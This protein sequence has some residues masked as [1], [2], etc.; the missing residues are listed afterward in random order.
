MLRIILGVFIILHALVH[1]LYFGQSARYFELQPGMIWP[2]GSW[3]LSK[4]LGEEANRMLAS[5][6]LVLA[7]AG[8]IAGGIGILTNQPW[9]RSLVIG[10]TVFSSLIF[11]LFWDGQAQHLGNKGFVGILI[12]LVILGIVFIIR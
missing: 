10:S 9:W 2:D 6:L 8:M 1:L 5:V 11:V 12:N 3:V 7:A 4:T